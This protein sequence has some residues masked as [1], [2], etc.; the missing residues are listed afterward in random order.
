M[1][2]TYGTWC[3]ELKMFSIEIKYLLLWLQ[4]PTAGSTKDLG[5]WKPQ[6]DLLLINAVQQVRHSVCVSYRRVLFKSTRVHITCLS[7][8]ICHSPICEEF[9]TCYVMF[10]ASIYVHYQHSFLSKL[11]RHPKIWPDRQSPQ[12]TLYGGPN[13]ARNLSV[14]LSIR[15]SQERHRL[16]LFSVYL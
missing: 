9:C 14:I 6:D 3:A 15:H 12:F 7:A 5:R 16:L 13:V 11:E 4:A 1:N 10:V 8:T 2:P